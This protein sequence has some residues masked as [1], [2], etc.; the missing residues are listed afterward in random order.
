MARTK[1][2]TDPNGRHAR[3]Y[4]SMLNSA[5]WRV[6]GFSA[7][8]LFIDL[9]AAVGPTNNGNISASLQEMKHRGW[10]SS[11]TLAKALYELRALGFIAV[12]VQGGLNRG[13]QV[14]S[15]YRFTDLPVFDQPKVGVLACDE[16]HDYRRFESVR[17]AEKALVDGLEKLQ[18][19]GRRKQQVK[20]KSGVRKSNPSSS[21]IEPVE[22]F[23]GSEIEHSV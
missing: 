23:S 4:H 13:K 16:T 5:A 15:L 7:K 10:V 1:Q 6:L 11:S 8:A 14:P 2:P 3:I 12:T 21:K 17:E 19:E 9:R 22:H 20:K 18:E